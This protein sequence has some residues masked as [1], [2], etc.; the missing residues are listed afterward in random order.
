MTTK[1][2][3]PW[4]NMN[5]SP[6][7]PYHVHA[8]CAAAA[9]VIVNRLNGIRVDHL[10]VQE[11]F[12]A[13]AHDLNYQ[14]YKPWG[15][16]TAEDIFLLRLYFNAFSKII[17]GDSLNLQNC[18]L[19]VCFKQGIHESQWHKSVKVKKLQGSSQLM[20]PENGV[21]LA[22]INIY[23]LSVGPNNLAR[24]LSEYLGILLHEMAHSYLQLFV[25]NQVGSFQGQGAKGHGLPWMRITGAIELFCSGVLGLPLKLGR[26]LSFALELV[27]NGIPD[28]QVPFDTLNVDVAAVKRIVGICRALKQQKQKQIDGEDA[29][30][31]RKR[32]RQN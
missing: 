4:C 6:A 14:L 3:F 10:L 30:R 27:A 13:Q 1:T 11:W 31:S 21:Q 28:E 5:N 17:F 16:R 26:S 8:T 22:V 12:A 24:R 29:G 2:R 32:Q 19:R 20:V 9:D 15:T 7:G 23:E 18:H 25:L